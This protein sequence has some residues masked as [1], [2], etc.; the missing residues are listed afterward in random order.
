MKLGAAFA[1]IDES[2]PV[3]AR[4]PDSKQLEGILKDIEE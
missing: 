2:Y 3:C 1:H 4:R